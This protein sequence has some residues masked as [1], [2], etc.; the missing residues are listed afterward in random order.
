MRTPIDKTRVAPIGP[1]HHFKL[2]LQALVY[3]S[4]VSG[5]ALA[6]GE[7]WQDSDSMKNRLFAGTRGYKLGIVR[8]QNDWQ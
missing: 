2:V 1:I 6:S 3:K 4:C 7:L 8:S 5:A